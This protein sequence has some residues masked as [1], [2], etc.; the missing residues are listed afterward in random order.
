MNS[1]IV[2]DR[3]DDINGQPVVMIYGIIVGQDFGIT[4]G[5]R[6]FVGAETIIKPDPGKRFIEPMSGLGASPE[7]ILEHHLDFSH[8]NRDVKKPYMDKFINPAEFSLPMKDDMDPFERI[9]ER[10]ERRMRTEEK[11]VEK[12]T[13]KAKCCCTT[14]NFHQ[15]GGCT[16]EVTVAGYCRFCYTQCLPADAA[17]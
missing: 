5:R 9:L 14:I 1:K 7:D 16:G 11:H 4:D 17:E 10:E 13:S 3:R 15:S 2:L 8:W 6:R 12:N